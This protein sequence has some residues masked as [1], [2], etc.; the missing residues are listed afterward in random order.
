M[1]NSWLRLFYHHR[2][3][4]LDCLLHVSFN[5]G[6]DIIECLHVL[7]CNLWLT[8]KFCHGASYVW[9]IGLS[10]EQVRLIDRCLT[11]RCVWL[12]CALN[13]IVHVDRCLIDR[14]L[15][16]LTGVS[17]W[18]VCLIDRCVYCDWQV[19]W[20]TFVWLTGVWRDWQVCLTDTCVWLTGVSK[21]IDRCAEWHVSDWQVSDVIDRC[22]W[23]TRVSDW[24]M[25]L[26]WLTGVLN[27]MCLIDRCVWL[28]GVSD[29]HV[30]LLWLKGVLND[31]CLIDRCVWCDW[32][33]CWMELWTQST[34]LEVSCLPC[35]LSFLLEDR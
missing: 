13:D 8:Q 19:C 25:C 2:Q 29:W 3:F 20:M 31:V 1:G 9:L 12:T 33:V 30:C 16:W 26:L 6:S 18:H 24:Q 15:T 5:V 21:V 34:V 4:V 28:T 10:D 22:V 23:L 27:D 35:L 7:E 11:D 17:D 14:C 32:Q